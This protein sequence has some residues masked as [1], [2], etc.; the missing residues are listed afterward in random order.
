MPHLLN[1][2]SRSS[3]VAACNF[4][5]NVVTVVPMQLLA[6]GAVI[7][8]TGRRRISRAHR[9][10]IRNEGRL[11]MRRENCGGTTSCEHSENESSNGESH[12]SLTPQ[13]W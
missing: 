7:R 4:C 2:K 10:V 1:E 5:G 9:L 11:R 8:A 6:D 13:K 3:G 12:D